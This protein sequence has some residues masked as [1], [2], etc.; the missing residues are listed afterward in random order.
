MAKE[1]YSAREAAQA[2][3]ISLDTLRRWD[4]DGRIRTERDSGNRRVVRAAE[5][6]RLRGDEGKHMSARNRL[7]GT[8]RDVRVDGL[9]AQ[10]EI[11]ITEPA[12]IV[13]IVTRDAVE[14]LGL[15]AGS[16]ATAIVKST[17]VMV[18]S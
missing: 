13:A 17:S 3:G 12:T 2:L 11:D 6:A 15:K 7:S 8:V 4:R 18:E 14:E 16:P 10:V 1:L 5:L 9:L